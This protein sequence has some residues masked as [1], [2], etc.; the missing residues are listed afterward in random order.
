MFN[1]VQYDFNLNSYLTNNSSCV[2]KQ[3][4]HMW[5]FMAVASSSCLNA[6]IKSY[7]G[8]V[9]ML[10]SCKVEYDK[11]KSNTFAVYNRPNANGPYCV[12]NNFVGRCCEEQL[13]C[14]SKICA[15]AFHRLVNYQT[16]WFDCI[17]YLKVDFLSNT[18]YFTLWLTEIKSSCA[19]SLWTM[20]PMI[21]SY[22]RN[23]DVPYL[24]CPL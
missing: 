3:Q 12:R 4:R 13:F 2:P 21:V 9:F 11:N 19:Y 14:E 10:E 20:N 17:D 7:M 18:L 16:N 22:F 5:R 15:K 8:P 6:E 24:N 23:F 1:I